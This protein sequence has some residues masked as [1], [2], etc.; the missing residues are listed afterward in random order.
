MR[1][2]GTRVQAWTSANGVYSGTLVEVIPSRPWRG[3]VLIDGVVEPA[4][5]WEMGKVRRGK[6]PGETI[7]VGGVNISATTLP[8]RTYLECLEAQKVA[9]EKMGVT[10]FWAQESIRAITRL[11]AEETSAVAQ[12]SGMP[13]PDRSPHRT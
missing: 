2:V 8:G 3:R 5:P 13:V 10:Q 4:C 12:D 9:F 6:R 1:L 7:E 11:I